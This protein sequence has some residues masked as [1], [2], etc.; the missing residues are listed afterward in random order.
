MDQLKKAVD[1]YI[2]QL[3]IAI[4]P[5]LCFKDFV[6]V[7]QSILESIILELDDSALDHFIHQKFHQQLKEHRACLQKECEDRYQ[8]RCRE[9][10]KQLFQGGGED[11]L[12]QSIF[13]HSSSEYAKDPSCI[14]RDWEEWSARFLSACGHDDQDQRSE[15]V[16]VES[17][18][19]LE[20]LTSSAAQV[21]ANMHSEAQQQVLVHKQALLKAKEDLDQSSLD[22]I[23]LRGE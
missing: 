12:R 4:A 7:E 9:A 18:V 19:M 11:D 22:I 10:H 1:N 14:E 23:K 13:H 8:T 6:N 15:G 3:E 16:G 17:R 2:Q 20:V 21:V 5:G